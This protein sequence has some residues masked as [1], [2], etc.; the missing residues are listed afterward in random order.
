MTC[1]LS[2]GPGEYG[3]E[4]RIGARVDG[5][6][7]DQEDFG[8]G[9]GDER[10]LERSGDGKEGDGSHAEEVGEYEHSHALGDLG[11]GAPPGELWV[12]QCQIYQHVANAHDDEGAHVEEE[13]DY[14]E[15][16]RRGSVYIHG[17]AHA[18]FGVT[19]HTSEGQRA[20]PQ[21]R[22]PTCR[23]NSGC[24][25]EPHAALHL[26]GVGDGVPAFHGD[27]GE[28][29]DRKLAAKHGQEACDAAARPRLPLDGIVAVAAVCAQVN[30]SDH[31]EVDANAQVRESQVAYEEAGHH[32][33][34]AGERDH[35]DCQ[36]A[37]D[38]QYANKPNGHS[39]E[40]ETG[41][42]LAGIEG[43]RL[44]RANQLWSRLT[45]V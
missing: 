2:E 43:V 10:D 4:E 45:G 19:A 35:E 40:T 25:P 33:L 34:P 38:G 6:E 3:I 37:H 32:Q 14:D 41:D 36:V 30:C 29:V 8:V 18:D 39:E 12:L 13:D 7:E 21:T 26:H 20:H 28:G 44:R 24:L 15:N 1:I 9:D 23:H 17:Q 31:Q 11:V 5:E 27:G 16:L 22:Q 42:V